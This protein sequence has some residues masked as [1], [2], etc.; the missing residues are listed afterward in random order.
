MQ[1][2]L[3]LPPFADRLSSLLVKT[4]DD[5]LVVI[6][7]RGKHSLT[8]KP[9][10][11]QEAWGCCAEYLSGTADWEQ[12]NVRER[13]LSDRDF[14]A[15]GV[16]NFRSAP[17][18]KMRDAKYAKKSIAFLHQASRYRGKAN[19]RRRDLLGLRQVSVKP[20]RALYR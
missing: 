13:V 11:S 3:A 8:M 5:E 7:A 14:K 15:L 12:W 16:D 9:I 6:R 19:Y 18:K 20:R 2:N 4:V 17:A 1:N 10:T